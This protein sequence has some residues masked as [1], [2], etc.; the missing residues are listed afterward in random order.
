MLRERAAAASEQNK[1]GGGTVAFSLQNGLPRPAQNAK[2]SHKK[3][4]LQNVA[5]T[6]N[7]IKAKACGK[8]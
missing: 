6:K 5:N 7:A 4:C 3:S 2:C 8:M 1:K